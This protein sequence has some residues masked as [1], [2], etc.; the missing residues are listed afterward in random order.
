MEYVVSATSLQLVS[1]TQNSVGGGLRVKATIEHPNVPGGNDV[2][3]DYIYTTGSGIS[4]GILNSG[5][6]DYTTTSLSFT[7]T[8]LMSS[9]GVGDQ[10]TGTPITP[11]PSY[12]SISSSPMLPSFFEGNYITYSKVTEQ[13]SDNA[14]KVSEY[15]NSDNPD[16]RDIMINYTGANLYKNNDFYFYWFI[17]RA[18]ER[19]KLLKESF[20]KAGA[21]SPEREIVYTY[22]ND[23]GRFSNKVNFMK[24]DGIEL[25]CNENKYSLRSYLSQYY[26]YYSY[27]KSKT[28]TNY[29][30]GQPVS[31]VTD[32]TYD[33]LQNLTS[34]TTTYTPSLK[35][36]NATSYCNSTAF[37]PSAG[38]TDPLI[39]SI[40]YLKSN[41]LYRYPIAQSVTVDKNGNQSIISGKV[42]AYKSDAPVLKSESILETNS[43]LSLSGGYTGLSVTGTSKTI[44][45][46]YHLN[47]TNVLDFSSNAPFPYPQT[48]D[49]NGQKTAIIRD[50]KQEKIIATVKNAGYSDVCYT[51]FEGTYATQ[52]AD[53]NKGNWGFNT[54]NVSP[55]A[56]PT[57]I[58]CYDMSYSGTGSF[59]NSVPLTPLKTY[60]ISYWRTTAPAINNRARLNNIT[61]LN[62]GLTVGAKIGTTW[63]FVTGKFVAPTQAVTMIGDGFID[64]LRMYPED[65]AMETYTYDIY[66][67]MSD[68]SDARGAI[69]YYEY[70]DLHR[71]ILVRDTDG[72]ILKK[73]DYAIQSTDVD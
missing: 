11:A 21:T 19:G 33:N 68:R 72:N 62:G 50:Y 71:L 2:R 32:Y 1:Q 3:R 26:S 46:H 51:S 64:E 40:L 44:D 61:F 29:F 65:A 4:S 30:N 27:L 34:Q 56:G 45:N 42:F 10:I 37:N 39:N 15:S 7:N 38:S 70:D 53:I 66:N 36:I 8:Y 54:N 60:V 57:G 55:F 35:Y 52:G 41:N 23:A 18:N 67:G 5:V 43:P 63:E 24:K 9:N 25:P 47:A 22:N 6:P 48:V 20:Y 13:T 17:S 14:T 69:T 12:T 16:Y 73:Y 58:K 49:N 31:V 59:S 28:E